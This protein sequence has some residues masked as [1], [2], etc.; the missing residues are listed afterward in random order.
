MT[1]LG[2]LF[3]H[4]DEKLPFPAF[5]E[6][7]RHLQYHSSF[8]KA[9]FHPSVPIEFR[10]RLQYLVGTRMYES[11]KQDHPNST[12]TEAGMVSPRKIA[13]L[14]QLSKWQ[15]GNLMIKRWIGG[16]R[17]CAR[18]RKVNGLGGELCSLVCLNK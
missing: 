11:L 5:A 7:F 13:R 2:H 1:L 3:K 4:S 10:E 8:F 12:M 9:I 16:L 15:F 6:A 14:V 18:L 17:L